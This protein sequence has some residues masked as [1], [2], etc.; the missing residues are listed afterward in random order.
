MKRP[1]QGR[2]GL[3]LVDLM[4]SFSVLVVALMAFS[5]SLV[6]SSRH[7][8][9]Q[10]QR[11]LALEGAR[12][13][14]E[15]LQSTDFDLVFALY[16]TDPADD[17]AGAGTAPGAGFAIAGLPVRPDDADGLVG[18][19]RFPTQSAGGVLELR[20]DL[21]NPS[22]G[23]PKDLSGDGVIDSADHSDDYQLLPVVVSV[24]WLSSSGPGRLELRT[25]LGR[26]W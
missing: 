26:L 17:P 4:V 14:M 16:N 20:E 13:A 5:Q 23:T 8:L 11:D 25:M 12:Q 1:G 18:E 9:G 3:T 21:V 7:A 15:R 24:E 2:R 19:I 22:F 10:G 6:G